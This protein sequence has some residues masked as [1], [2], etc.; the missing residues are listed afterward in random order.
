VPESQETWDLHVHVEG[1]LVDRARIRAA[2]TQ[3][4]GRSPAL[5]TTVTTGCRQRRP[6][7][8]T[9]VLPDRVTCRDAARR[10]QL[11]YAEL[12]EFRAALPTTDPT[13]ADEA[14]RRARHHRDVAARFADPG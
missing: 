6:L 1:S 3:A 13:A 12:L 4:L 8:M 9:S 5:P 10:V 14:R 11:R 2:L 7:A